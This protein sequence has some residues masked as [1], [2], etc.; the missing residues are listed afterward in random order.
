MSLGIPDERALVQRDGLPEGF[1]TATPQSLHEILPQPTL[2]HL[3]GR[4]QAPLFVSI[5]LH[6]NE[7]TGLT[8]VQ[9]VLH[10]HLGRGLPRALSIF[11]GNV[12]AARHDLRHLDGQTD[13]NRIWP[14]TEA[15]ASI[16]TRI[17]HEVVAAMAARQVF[18][19]I[20]IHN[21][22]GL[23]P[24]YGCVN[25]LDAPF[26]HL[27]A[28]F[29]R[30]VVFFQR[31]LGVQSAAFAPLCPS[32]TVECGKVGSAAGI[33]A[34]ARFVDAALHLEHFPAHPVRA[35]DIDV[36]HTVATVKVP[37]G[38]EFGFGVAG[39]H[40]ST[41]PPPHPS[42]G[43]HAHVTFVPDL[44]HLNFR[45]L[46]PGTPIARVATAQPPL[47][48]RNEDGAP[49]FE[50]WFEVRGGALLTRCAVTPAMLTLDA[51]VIRQDCLCYLMSR[52]AVGD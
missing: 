49:E 13:F 33:D 44:D 27:A 51:R 40:A 14:G 5:L 28:L 2:L 11:V 34:A 19:S 23:N 31:P 45:E 1:L 10:A 9:R 32:V 22:T 41:N 17:A 38:I 52:I 39:S 12:Q 26:L 6:G 43:S 15:E 50:R 18:A 48:V 42:A 16:D 29:S 21:N 20:D 36:F 37:E 4:R 46:P 8:A 30:T 7:G 25:R 47:D 3:P 35:Q 24:H